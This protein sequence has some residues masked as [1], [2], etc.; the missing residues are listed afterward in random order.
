MKKKGKTLKESKEKLKTKADNK[1]SRSKKDRTLKI[2]TK[3]KSTAKKVAQKTLNENLRQEYQ[4]TLNVDGSPKYLAGMIIELDESWG[5][6]EGKYVI[7]KVTHNITGD[8]TCEINAMKL[9]A[10]EIAE[11]N[12]IAQTK[13]EQNKKEAEKAKKKSAKKSKSKTTSNGKT[14]ATK[15]AKKARDKKNTTKSGNKK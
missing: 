12:A 7:D 10:R 15:S 11:K 5:K 4:I 3:G 6:F 14:T 8:Y 9:G 1:K 2:K 13:E